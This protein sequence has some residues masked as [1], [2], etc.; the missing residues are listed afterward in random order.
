MLKIYS[1]VLDRQ[2]I[3]D[4]VSEARDTIPITATLE[5]IEEM[6]NTRVRSR[7]W[8]IRLSNW[9]SNRHRNSGKYGANTWDSPPATWDD[10]GHV[11]AQIFRRDP[12]A[13]IGFYDGEADFHAYTSDAYALPKAEA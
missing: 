12:N 2:D 11:F 6:P 8:K 5:D 10:H 4:S 13:K 1:D 3:I 9:Q 7:G